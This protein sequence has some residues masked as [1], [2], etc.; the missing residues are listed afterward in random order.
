MKDRFVNV[1]LNSAVFGTFY[2]MKLI[3]NSLYDTVMGSFKIAAM[4]TK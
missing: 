3:S 2:L 1:M 4:V